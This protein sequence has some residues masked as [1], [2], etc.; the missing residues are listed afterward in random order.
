MA[1]LAGSLWASNFSIT[2]LPPLG[3]SCRMT[4]TDRRTHLFNP[5]KCHEDKPTL[6]KWIWWTRGHYREPRYDGP[7]AS[8]TP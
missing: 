4:V 5:A 7:P 3:C 8:A 1:N 6:S 2:V